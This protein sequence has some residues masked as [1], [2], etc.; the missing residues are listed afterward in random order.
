MDDFRAI[1]GDLPGRL[2]IVQQGVQRN[3]AA[4]LGDLGDGLFVPGCHI[5]G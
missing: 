1:T 4:A 2:V 3:L 5:K